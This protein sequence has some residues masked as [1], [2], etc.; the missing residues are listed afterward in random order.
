MLHGLIVA[1]HVIVCILLVIVVLTQSGESA[2][3]AAAFGG[4]GSQAAFGPRGTAT[5]LTRVTTWLAVIFMITSIALSVME[6]GATSSSV[7]GSQP[8]Q[9]QS[10][11]AKKK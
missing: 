11:P 3:L 1:I 2:D 10:Q 7:F 8:T 5:V 6:S 9:Q 4:A